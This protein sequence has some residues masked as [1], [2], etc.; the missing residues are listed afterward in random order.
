M[1]EVIPFHTG[2]NKMIYIPVPSEC[3]NV[4]SDKIKRLN[5]ALASY[6]HAPTDKKE[7]D[8]MKIGRCHSGV[9][10]HTFHS[11]GKGELP[12]NRNLQL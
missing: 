12:H 1:K 8:R 6:I 11:I 5:S 7:T 4:L 9:F 10:L 2:S 3:D